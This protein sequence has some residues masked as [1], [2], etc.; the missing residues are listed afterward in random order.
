M[1]MVQSYPGKDQG[2]GRGFLTGMMHDDDGAGIG[3]G[4]EDGDRAQEVKDS[5]TGVAN[6]ERSWFGQIRASPEIRF[7]SYRE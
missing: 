6:H 2:G 3:N 4:L 5:S 1:M 7:D